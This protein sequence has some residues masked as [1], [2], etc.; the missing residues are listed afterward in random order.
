[1]FGG[2]ILSETALQKMTTPFLAGYA[3]GLHV[4]QTAEGA[5][6]YHGGRIDGFSA[7]L[8]YYRRSKLSVVTLSNVWNRDM[9]AINNELAAVILDGPQP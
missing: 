7:H 1:L 5:I 8:A 3:C 2:K 4:Q 9:A 6:L